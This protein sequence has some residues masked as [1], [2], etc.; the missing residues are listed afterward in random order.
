MSYPVSATRRSGAWIPLLVIALIVVCAA[1]G[2]AAEAGEAAHEA[3][4]EAGHHAAQMKDFM[5]RWIDFA[6]LVAIIVWGLKKGN[7][8]GSLRD[9][10]GNI[11]KML[12]EAVEA[13][14][15][16]EQKLQEYTSKLE[17]ANKEID[18]IS[19][20][21]RKEGELEKERIIAEAKANAEKIR[22]QAKISAEQEVRKATAELREEAARLAVELAGKK[23]R[24]KMTKDDQDRLVGDY[25]AKVVD[26]Q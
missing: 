17:Q 13:R 25:L 10:R 3:A 21:I 2:F 14:K 19:A 26:L 20:A 15:A 6:V 7:V 23:I 4:H 24:E 9:R 8:A 12:N 22:E 1:A 16:A 5:W 11:E 18:E